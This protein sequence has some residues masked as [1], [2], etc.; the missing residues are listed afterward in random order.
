MRLWTNTPDLGSAQH[1]IHKLSLASHLDWIDS[2]KEGAIASAGSQSV[3]TKGATC[4]TRLFGFLNRFG[5]QLLLLSES[6]SESTRERFLFVSAVS[7]RLLTSVCAHA[8]P[9]NTCDVWLSSWLAKAESTPESIWSA[10]LCTLTLSGSLLGLDLVFRFGLGG[11]KL[12]R[13]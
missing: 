10:K 9:P 11:K 12:L 8:S 2:I 13:T 4:L 6:E 7:A 3:L 5:L 1:I